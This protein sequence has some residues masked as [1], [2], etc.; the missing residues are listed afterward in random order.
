MKC[1][2]VLGRREEPTDGVEDYCSYLRE[3]LAA[4]DVNLISMRVQWAEMGWPKGR[5]EFSAAIRGKE[6]DV[7][8]LQ[9]TALAWSR[10][11]FPM[12]AVGILKALKKSGAQCGVV[13]HD[14]DGYAGNRLID[15]VR[16]RLQR[17]TMRRL[18]QLSD[19]AIFTLA[20][21]KI[22]WLPAEARKVFCIPVGAN[23]PAPERAWTTARNRSAGKP[24]VAIFSLSDQPIRTHEVSVIVE[25]VSYA[26]KQAGPLQIV[27]IGRNSEVGA[28]ELRAQL[29]GATVDVKALGLISAEDI[30]NQ[31]GAADAMLF[32]RGSI[33][34]RRGSAIAGVACGLPVIALHGSE[35]APPITEAGVAFV[36]EN[37]TKEFGP[38]LTRV[39]TDLTYRKE[40]AERSRNAQSRYFSWKAIAIQYAQALRT[41]MSS[42]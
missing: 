22:S 27:L 36:P 9:Y 3:A 33:S 5:K 42:R 20:L 11:G 14:P 31:L 38:I 17:R 8:L 37:S 35:V 24:V 40:L 10:R 41:T 21:E 2:A 29:S 26:A 12:R 4:E 25:A 19:V 13:F 32:P 28:E 15:R 6:N 34:T 30:V 7:F 39:L 18:L 16:R 23:L 1:I